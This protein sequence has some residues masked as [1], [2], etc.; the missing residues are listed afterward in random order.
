MYLLSEINLIP[1]LLLLS[2]WMLGG[3]LIF[4][5]EQADEVL[6]FYNDW[7]QQVPSLL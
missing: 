1:A 5:V 4:D 6:A 3:W 7:I 2:L